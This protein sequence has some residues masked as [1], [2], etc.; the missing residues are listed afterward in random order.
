MEAIATFLII[1][2]AHMNLSF[3]TEVKILSSSSHGHIGPLII[4]PRMVI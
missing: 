4:E 2:G 3:V 1:L